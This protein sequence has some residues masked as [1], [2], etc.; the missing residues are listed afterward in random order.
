MEQELP[1]HEKYRPKTFSE[2][3]GNEETVSTLEKL[4]EKKAV[5][6]YMLHGK[7]GCGKTTLAHIMAN[8]LGIKSINNI[9]E[10]DL[11]KAG[12]KDNGRDL[13]K[14][15]IRSPLSGGSTVFILDEIQG[16]SAGFFQ[17]V[18]KLFEKPKAKKYFILCTTDP[19]KIPETI[20][21]RC[22]QFEVE[23][24]NFKNANKLINRICKKENISIKKSESRAIINKS[25]GCA[26]EILVLLEKISVIDDSDNRIKIIDGHYKSEEEKV[27][28]LCQMLINRNSW[29]EISSFLKKMKDDPENTRYAILGY[30]NAV[31]LNS[32]SL[33]IADM[34]SLFEGS[35][36]Y[37]KKAGLTAACRYAIDT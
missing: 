25:E 11:G 21:S 8:S 22:S 37:S 4:V 33:K 15:A 19:N 1:F 28:E 16:A 9:K 13:N 17:T 20:R 10:I 29:K 12:N 3:I 2:I 23:S 5:T 34:I 7:R 30:L 32:G 36:I 24:L 27:N 6:T 35:F 31:L 18:L 14:L 26:R